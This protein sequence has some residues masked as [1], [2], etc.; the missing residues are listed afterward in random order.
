MIYVV[1]GFP[2]SGKTTFEDICCK[3]LKIYGHKIS[4][5]DFVKIIARACG[6][7]GLKTPENRKFLSDLKDLLTK[8]NDV[9][10]KEI[11]KAIDKIRL[12]F[13][14][15]DMDFKKCVIF[16]DCREPDE[17]EKI[18]TQLNAKSIL[19]RRA[20]VEQDLQSNHADSNILDYSYD[21]I[22]ENNGSLEDLEA[23][24]LTFMRSENLIDKEKDPS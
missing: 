7:N 18:C 8:W 9:P 22:I 4:T 10:F 11:V 14:N 16:I 1:N 6:W 23:A 5:V 24:A 21:I 3:T 15:Y 17:I 12:Q 13:K 2:G 20:K 19:V